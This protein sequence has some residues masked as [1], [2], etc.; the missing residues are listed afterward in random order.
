MKS[1]CIIPN[2]ESLHSLVWDASEKP[3]YLREYHYSMLPGDT[4]RRAVAVYYSY[5]EEGHAKVGALGGVLFPHLLDAHAAVGDQI[6]A[7]LAPHGVT[8]A[9]TAF[10]AAKRLSASLGNPLLSPTR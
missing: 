2:P 3:L 10:I 9:D 5:G 7:I 6:A 4:L 1:Y 8:A